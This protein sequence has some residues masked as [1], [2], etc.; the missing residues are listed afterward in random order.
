[1]P[2]YPIG[3]I[4]V[5]DCSDSSTLL[6]GLLGWWKLDETSGSTC[7]DSSGNDNDGSISGATIN[8]TGHIDK[9]YDFD[10]SN[11]R[12]TISKSTSIGTG[13]YSVSCWLKTTS[14]SRYRCFF[15]I[16]EYDPGFYLYRGDQICVYDESRKV[17]ND[18]LD[19]DDGAWHHVAIVREGTG[20]GELKFYLDGD[21]V[22]TS[23]HSDS[24]PNASYLYI[25]ATEWDDEVFDGMI[26]DVRFY[27][28]ALTADEVGELAEM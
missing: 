10:G 2:I 3:G 6:N 8:Q 17:S 14:T 28:R 18:N 23:T 19:T 25:G 7:E 15:C 4:G 27:T 1:M 20:S 13:D 16:G 21:S 11:D 5:C 12:V 24:I 9:A 22:G 26:D